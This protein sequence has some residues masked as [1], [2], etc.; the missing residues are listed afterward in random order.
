M[1]W[2]RHVLV[3]GAMV[4]GACAFGAAPT[5]QAL[6]GTLSIHLRGG[7]LFKENR[8]RAGR[9]I[10]RDLALDVT[11]CQGRWQ[12]RVWG[13]GAWLP[14]Q[15]HVGEL[16]GATDDGQAIELRVKL[17]IGHSRNEPMTLGG[18]AEL[19]IKLRPEG[20]GFVGSFAGQ[21]A[22]MNRPE[23]H[24]EL[25]KAWGFG[26]SP[27]TQEFFQPL[28]RNR[29]A[30]YLAT[31]KVEG[32]ATA[33][34][35]RDALLAIDWAKVRGGEHPRLLFR[36]DDLPRLRQRAQSPQG[37]KIMAQLEELLDRAQKYGFAYFPP[38]AEHSM[39]NIWGTGHALLYQLTGDKRHADRA[40]GLC[41]ANLYGSYYYGGGWLHAYTMLG[42]ALCYDM[43]YDAWD[44]EFRDIIYVYL[45]QNIR[46]LAMRHEPADYLN[47]SER[48]VF[49]NDQSRFSLSSIRDGYH[50]KFRASAAMAAMALLNDPPAA[51]NPPPLEE[52]KVIE[53][54]RDY[55]PWIGVPVEPFESDIMP[56]NW[57]VNGPFL[58]GKVDEA[59]AA[60]GGCSGARPEPGTMVLS[61]GVGVDFRVYRPAGADNPHGGAIYTRNCGVYWGQGTG[62][63]YGPGIR[64][65]Q[66]WR[67]QYNQRAAINVVLYV[68]IDN[69]RE[70]VVQALPN[71]RSASIGNRMWINGVQVRDGDLVRLK[72]GLYPL[73]VDVQ[74][75]G[76]YSH[77][78]PK[79]RQYTPQMRSRDAQQYQQAVEAYTG[80][81]NEMM[82]NLTSLV[83]SVRRYIPADIGP[84][85]WDVW[86]SQ[87]SLLPM[88]L[89]LRQLTGFDLA[90]GTSLQK[91]LPLAVRLRGH[92][93]SRPLDYMI[94]Q[95][96][97]LMPPE[98]VPVA[99]WYL[100][101]HGLGIARPI[102]AM[103]AMLTHPFDVKP[104]PPESA[105]Q[106]ASPFGGYG[107]HAFRSGWSGSRDALT[108]LQTG[109]EGFTSPYAAG[110]L[111]LHALGR[112]WLLWHGG[113]A[114]ANAN[115]LSIRDFLPTRHARLLHAQYETDGSGSV[116]YQIDGFRPVQINDPKKMRLEYT[117]AVDPEMA[118]VRAFGV[119]YSRRSGAEVLIVMADT[120]ARAAFREKVWRFDLG[121]VK[122]EGHGA[123]ARYGL[124][125]KD[126]WFVSKPRPSPRMPDAPAGASMK[127]TVIAPGKVELID[128]N[129][130]EGGRRTM[131]EVKI[132]RFVDH[133]E[134]VVKK[135]PD[136]DGSPGPDEDLENLEAQDRQTQRKRLGPITVFT[137]LTVQSGDAPAV[138]AAGKGD[139]TVLT[140]GGQSARF[141]GKRIVFGP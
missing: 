65:Q 107:I 49:A 105:L 133:L 28:I 14:G 38:A 55:E 5:T 99:R 89:A 77:Q 118:A 123:D 13:F 48:F 79:L 100:D 98:H 8:G 63:G 69:D 2:W 18:D 44:A 80:P 25:E 119:D 132:D 120:I 15:E 138:S 57:L 72:R 135:G 16:V 115:N 95:G 17:R 68:V 75:V 36:K 84:D 136:P 109:G 60:I 116:T 103:I 46:Q 121:D 54:A 86:E 91:L 50:N 10:A 35:G 64:L 87:E 108:T 117:G 101:Q 94:S 41:H 6:D 96:V 126:N 81:D 114:Y 12:K 21:C 76:G 31:G 19:T 110:D 11:R 125:V 67:E 20:E 74:L 85:G 40:R 39:G 42:L 82:R 47:T 51:F 62:G 24:V 78:A 3:V 43:C 29:L 129:Y 128:R 23:V 56:R 34:L 102:D 71:W 7:L 88:T 140:V 32:P 113:E 111:Y 130:G 104:Q 137:I 37:R 30:A 134:K 70:R 90:E 73:M 106:R 97:A 141:D 122:E 112:P 26:Y 53:P 124:S 66:K 93:P 4:L 22:D 83:R 59:M 139:Q 9:A 1:V 61:D 27:G 92:W 58:R 45:E 131:V 52:A 127:V 33:T